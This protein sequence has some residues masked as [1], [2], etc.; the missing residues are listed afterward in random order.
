VFSFVRAN[1]KDKVFVALNLSGE[2]AKASF[3]KTLHHGTYRDFATGG[4]VAVDAAT[5]F[6]LAPWSYRVLVK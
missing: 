5:S 4:K 2:P 1:A 3:G 6:A